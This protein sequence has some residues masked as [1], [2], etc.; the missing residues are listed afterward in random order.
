MHSL[1]LSLC[2]NGLLYLSTT[3]DAADGISVT[4]QPTDY[5]A[6]G[7][8]VE[9]G[10]EC[11]VH[12][13]SLIVVHVDIALFPPNQVSPTEWFILAKSNTDV[14]EWAIELSLTSE[15]TNDFTF[16]PTVSTVSFEVDGYRVAKE[17]DML[18]S[19]TA[20]LCSMCSSST[21]ALNW[22]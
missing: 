20:S 9:F 1:S 11:T 7:I 8:A 4:V 3:D 2:A 13:P 22:Q 6:D 16:S 14:E 19:N 12:S 10:T 21:S 5:D 15:G 17:S 18:L